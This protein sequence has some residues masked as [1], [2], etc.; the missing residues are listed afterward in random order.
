MTFNPNYPQN[1]TAQKARHLYSD[2][3]GA[4]VDL[5]PHGHAYLEEY[6][7]IGNRVH[8]VAVLAKASYGEGSVGYQSARYQAER[9]SEA[10][11]QTAM[12][13]YFDAVYELETA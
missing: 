11:Y 12:D 7:A 3:Y 6:S 4:T 8:A 2:L 9:L 10:E 13:R 5:E 1:V